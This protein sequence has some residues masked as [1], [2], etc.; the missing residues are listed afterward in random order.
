MSKI[1]ATR[2]IC[3]G[4]QLWEMSSEPNVWRKFFQKGEVL[5][6]P[7]LWKICPKSDLN[8][9]YFD[10]RKDCPVDGDIFRWC[11]GSLGCKGRESWDVNIVEWI[12]FY[13]NPSWN[14]L[15]KDVRLPVQLQRAMAAEAEAAREARAKVKTRMFICA[16]SLYLFPSYLQICGSWCVLE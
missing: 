16:I 4:R 2:H 11:H 3:W 8:L 5:W 7:P 1:I 12:L 15:S 9:T 10:K 6:F 14:I 13:G